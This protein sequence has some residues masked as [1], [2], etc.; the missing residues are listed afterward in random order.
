[1]SVEDADEAIR[2]SLAAL[3]RLGREYGIAMTASRVRA[4]FDERGLIVALDVVD[5][6][7]G[8]K[9]EHEFLRAEIERATA[10][11]IPP[12][13]AAS[14]ALIDVWLSGLD[15]RPP[16]EVTND[17]HS[18]TVSADLGIITAVTIS[19]R[20]LG[21]GRPQTI[22]D[23]VLPVIRRAQLESDRLGVFGGIG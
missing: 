8:E 3:D 6:V 7:D 20:I 14:P 18:V 22:C 10:G 2:E 17:L 19:R 4:S 15:A 13:L 9:M 21:G 16:V 23:E 1:M 11:R 5:V 12:A